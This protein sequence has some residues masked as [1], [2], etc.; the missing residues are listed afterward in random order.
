[1]RHAAVIGHAGTPAGSDHRRVVP[2]RAR[3]R[4]EATGHIGGIAVPFGGWHHAE[5]RPATDVRLGDR[6][7]MLRA[8]VDEAG[9]RAARGR[10]SA[11]SHDGAVT[12]ILDQRAVGVTGTGAASARPAPRGSSPGRLARCAGRA[13][14]AR[15]AARSRV[16]WSL[17][18][19][20]GRPRQRQRDENRCAGQTWAS[21]LIHPPAPALP[22][23]QVMK[24]PCAYVPEHDPNRGG[25]RYFI[26][27]FHDSPDARRHHILA[28]VAS[29]DQAVLAR[30]V[31][32]PRTTGHAGRE[33]TG[34]RLPS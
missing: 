32:I 31:C 12:A 18:A 9:L 23:L 21:P 27:Q 13:A 3:R 15:C 10:R 17:L 2:C 30:G 1:V 4:W 20:T 34:L 16:D 24:R 19:V 26:R 7:A 28:R 5:A 8:E 6:D 11:R 14:H 29:I 33:E 22:P 25:V